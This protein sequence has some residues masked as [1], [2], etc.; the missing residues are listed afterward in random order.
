MI[1][2]ESI[3]KERAHKSV[4]T[5]FKTLTTTPYALPVLPTLSFNQRGMVAG[6]ALLNKNHIRLNASLLEKHPTY[7][8][9]QVIPHELAHL[10]VYYHF[11]RVKPHGK[12]WKTVMTKVY[13]LPPHRCHNLP[14]EDT[15]IRTFPY[16]CDCRQIQL[17]I[18][19]HNKVIRGKA[20]YTCNTC[21][22]PLTYLCDE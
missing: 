16:Q 8:Y 21:G 19:R 4:K 20:T 11:G 9:N 12:E 5:H 7:F 13:A 22:T 2:L 10:A 17:S 6:A 14:A 3:T 18:R 1:T 15:S